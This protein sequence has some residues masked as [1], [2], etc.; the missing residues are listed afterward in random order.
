MAPINRSGVQLQVAKKLFS[1]GPNYSVP[2][3]EKSLDILELLADQKSGLTQG[4][5]S[6][7]VGRS[8]NQIYRVLQ[9]LERRGYI[10][11]DET[12]GLYFLSVRLFELANS[13]PPMRNLVEAALPAMRRLTD[14]IQQSCNLSILDAGKVLVI[15]QVESA[16]AFGFRVRIGAQFPLFDNATG[17]TMMAFRP[18]DEVNRWLEVARLGG[19]R[20]DEKKLAASFASIRARGFEEEPHGTHSGVID[21]AMPVRGPTGGPIAVLT[22]PYISTSYSAVELPTVRREAQQAAADIHA[23]FNWKSD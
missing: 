12:S 8:L 20:I 18:Q 9:V 3:L 16:A 19:L 6:A 23:Q 17:R 15:A 1:D 22:V 21:L 4:Q 5:I 2:A 7:A 11:R 10:F 13:H 14:S